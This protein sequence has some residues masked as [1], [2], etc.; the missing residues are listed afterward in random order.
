MGTLIGANV[1]TGRAP[2]AAGLVLL[3]LGLVPGARRAEEPVGTSPNEF[4]RRAAPTF[5]VGTAGDDR[6]DREIRSQAEL[7]RDRLF[8]MARIV[9]DDSIEVERGPDAWPPGPVLYGG[10]QA[11]RLLA[12]LAPAL[13]FGLGRGTL[14]IG[15]RRFLGEDYRLIAVV[16]ARPADRDGPGYP[17]FLLYAGTGSP[18][19]AEINAVRHGPEPILVADAFGRLLTGRWRTDGDG[20]PTPEFPAAPARRIA[21]R[22]LDRELRPGDDG[23]GLAVRVCF[24]A[25]L[26]PA[27]DEAR[28]LD[29]CLRGITD[30]ARRLSVGGATRMD[31]Y[32]YPDRRSKAT[33]TGNDGD[34]HADLASHSLH[35]IRF[36]PSQGAGLER[37]VAHE[38]THLLTYD[39]WGVA[40]TPL[41]GEGVA[42]WVSGQ[43]GGV[44]LPDWP[45]RLP[46]EGLAVADLLGVRFRQLPEARTYPLA[47][48]F[49]EAAV[50]Q[51]GL[52]RFRDH[53]YGATAATWDAA[54]GR[55][56]TTPQDLE[57]A[58]RTALTRKP[59]P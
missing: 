49:V 25:P 51:V 59:T 58:F 17:D 47:G 48:L 15:G 56:G 23:A 39:R 20:R 31:V 16:P 46:A 12:R 50:A 13:P 42:V 45:G 14:E 24:P 3:I 57:A 18:G 11:N 7:V 21:W 40:G 38:S 6:S 8:P 35:V 52:D 28:V 37:L 44:L 9:T 26:P 1:R 33:L 27:D 4:L 29:A 41:L 10:P 54:C 30:A 34:G 43:Y 32:V 2:R 19:V 5:V 22:R 53:L 55:A 36:D